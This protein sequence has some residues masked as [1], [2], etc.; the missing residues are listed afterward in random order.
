MFNITGSVSALVA[1]ILACLTLMFVWGGTEQVTFNWVAMDDDYSAADLAAKRHP[2]QSYEI[3]DAGDYSNAGGG[4]AAPVLDGDNFVLWLNISGFRADY[5]E[6]AETPFLDGVGGSSTRAMTPTFPAL[7]WS[8]LMSQATGLTADGHGV[9]GNSMR[10][11]GTGEVKQYPSDLS[12]LK[13]EPIWTTAK[14]AG[15]GVLVHDWPFSQQ[16]PAEGGADIFKPTFDISLS[17]EDRLNAIFDAWS[18]HTGETK[19]RLVMGSLHGLR[20]AA[21]DYGTREEDTL[22]AITAMDS[23]LSGFFK[24]LI[25][26]WPDLR[27]GDGDKLHVVLT[28][29]HG[30]VDAEKLINFEDLMGE[31][32]N[33]VDYVVDEGI[34]HLWFKDTPPDGMDMDEFVEFYDSELKKRIYW[35]SFAPDAYP[36]DWKLAAEGGHLGDRLLLL[37]PPYA[38]HTEKGSEGVYA[39]AETAGPFAASG[40]W[41]N[42][43]SR[44]KGQMFAFSLTGGGGYSSDLGDVR[45]TQV[46]PSVL[47]LLGLSAPTDLADSEGLGFE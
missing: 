16:Q 13:A 40:Y 42:D 20:K 23:T 30:M 10:D 11:P 25:D 29:D 44:M 22:K 17:D 35:R 34:A 47:Q 39:P 18:S 43:S 45:A 3:P 21:Q 28:T 15:L 33:Q 38:F 4:V 36:S 14:K 5:M 9:V 12:L 24:K 6:K 1:A 2:I 26:K 7:N 27:G 37:K 8:S 41:V 32:A 31:M 46:Y 19:L